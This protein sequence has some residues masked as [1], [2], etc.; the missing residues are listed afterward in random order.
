MTTRSS[1]AP[2]RVDQIVFA[3]SDR[4]L[5]GGRGLGPV[6]TSLGTDGL[7]VWNERLAGGDVAVGQ[8]LAGAAECAALGALR[9]GRQ[10]EHGAALRLVPA[11]DPNGRPSQLVHALVGSASVVNAAL[12]LGLHRWPEWSTPDRLDSTPSELE[13]LD[14]AAL[15]AHARAGLDEPSVRRD[16]LAGLLAGVLAAPS[17]SYLAEISPDDVGLVAGLVHR[18]DGVAGTAP[19]TML[20]GAQVTRPELRPRLLAVGLPDARNG[21]TPLTTTG[22]ADPGVARVAGLL[23]DLPA[24]SLTRPRSP[25]TSTGALA[26]WVEAEHQR[27]TGGLDLVDRAIAGTLDEPA[28]RYLNGPKGQEQLRADLRTAGTA[29]LTDRL[30]RWTEAK[31]PGLSEA[32]RTLRQVAAERYMADDGEDRDSADRLLEAARRMGLTATEAR[33]VLANWYAGLSKVTSA[34]QYSAVYFA[35]GAGIDP[36]SDD[37][38]AR[39]LSGMKAASLLEWS[40]L[41]APSDHVQAAPHFMR[42]AYRQW[43]RG[44]RRGD[45]DVRALMRETEM[46]HETIHDIVSRCG[47]RAE[48]ENDLYRTVLHLAYG[49][50]VTDLAPVLGALPA[51]AEATQ[52]RPWA[53]L[54]DVLAGDRAHVFQLAAQARRRKAPPSVLEDMLGVLSSTDLVQGLAEQ[55]GQ[56]GLLDPVCRVLTGRT[57]TP[58]EKRA[59]CDAALA[60]RF[61]AGLVEK[62]WPDEPGQRFRAYTLL[63]RAVYQA[64]DRSDGGGLTRTEVD[65]LVRAGGTATFLLA[66]AAQAAPDA[67]VPAL[68]HTTRRQAADLGLSSDITDYTVRG[69]LR[70][71]ETRTTGRRAA[72]PAP[73]GMPQGRHAQDPHPV[74]PAGPGPARTAPPLP[75]P[76]PPIPPQSFSFDPPTAPPDRFPSGSEQ[77]PP[78]DGRHPIAVWIADRTL[79]EW[80]IAVVGLGIVVLLCLL[81]FGGS[82]ETPPP[83]RVAPTVTVTVAPSASPTTASPG[84]GAETPAAG[85]GTPTGGRSPQPTTEKTP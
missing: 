60:G 34:D 58:A 17:D 19:L 5:A 73:A 27:A 39:L 47:L 9:F 85:D 64:G 26:D 72:E 53:A 33:R 77:E 20:L 62:A 42:A 16:A 79:Q 40:R 84:D 76:E 43:S 36:A 6:A 13:A 48:D 14:A 51:D 25:L 11:R 37:T 57:R 75:L 29:Q 21:R 4:L 41:L 31:P 65:E 30:L 81:L 12:V 10:G 83:G 82:D 49:D 46:F 2:G 35:L 1:P 61:L 52:F 22:G 54:A 69:P 70:A 24:A 32:T 67:V 18:L 45:E 80:A 63:L 78:D 3:W 7:R 56:P 74:R 50:P 44:D 55:P 66:V 68:L 71:A 23:A 28:R 8:W 15:W 38:F 59:I